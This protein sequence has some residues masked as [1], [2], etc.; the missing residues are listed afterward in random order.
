MEQIL[1]IP[2]QDI[3]GS[4]IETYVASESIDGFRKMI[5]DAVE[6]KDLSSKNSSSFGTDASEKS[7]PDAKRAKFKEDTGGEQSSP[8]AKKARF[9][10]DTIVSESKAN[11]VHNANEVKKIRRHVGLSSIV[12]V[13]AAATFSSPTRE[14][15]Q[16]INSSS[17][18]S[19][20][21]NKITKDKGASDSCSSA[22]SSS[23]AVK[24][25]ALNVAL[26]PTFVICLVRTDDSKVWCELTV[27]VRIKSVSD[28]FDT[29]NIIEES[30]SDCSSKQPDVPR[31]MMELLL[32]FR[33]L[34]QGLPESDL[35]S[36]S[37]SNSREN[38]SHDS[39]ETNGKGMKRNEN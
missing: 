34:S 17:I 28:D 37:N 6:P 29:D 1:Q 3:T 2:V 30:S 35:T 9:N 19:S 31:E 36:S 11:S 5:R 23:D 14:R 27:S 25:A 12:Q 10:E 24:D 22:S 15:K 21:G 26:A 8:A 33:P 20:P 39:N 4:N 7:G 38:G 18:D 32:C 16:S 13:S